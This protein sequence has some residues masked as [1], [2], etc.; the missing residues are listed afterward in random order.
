VNHN[1]FLYEKLCSLGIRTVLLIGK[2]RTKVKWEVVQQD[3]SIQCIVAND[4]IASEGLDLPRLSAL[5]NTCPTSNTKK[6]EQQLGRIRRVYPGKLL[7]L[8]I[9]ICDNLA[10][11]NGEG[12]PTYLLAMLSRKRCKF[13]QELKMQYNA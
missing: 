6:L 8:A 12:G 2:T 3:E 5:I 10:Y 1:E 13:Y 11:S 4:K 7:P 9:D